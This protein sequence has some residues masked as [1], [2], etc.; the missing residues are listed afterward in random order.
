MWATLQDSKEALSLKAS[1]REIPPEFGF[2]SSCFEDI[3]VPNM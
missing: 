1:E 3:I 2:A